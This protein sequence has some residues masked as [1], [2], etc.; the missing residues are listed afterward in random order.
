M[1]TLLCVAVL[2]ILSSCS[3]SPKVYPQNALE[4]IVILGI[5]DF[6]GSL[7]QRTEKTIESD[8]KKA[9]IYQDGGAA[10]FAS[11]VKIL[12]KEQ[13]EKLLVVDAGDEWQGSLDSNL[14]RGST[15]V[16][17][18]NRIGVNVA[19]IGNHEFD[20]GSEPGHPLYGNDLRG[21]MKKRFTEAKYPYVAANI[22]KKGTKNRE[23]FPNTTPTKIFQIGKVKVGVIGLSTT[24]TPE[25][26]RYDA[27]TDLEFR[28]LKDETLEQSK[29]LRNQGADIIIVTTHA[30]V[31]CDPALGESI[32]ENRVRRSN[33]PQG[34]CRDYDELYRYLDS[35]PQGT[36]DLVVSGHTHTILHHWI[37]GTPVIQAGAFNH[38][39]NIATLTY[40]HESKKVVPELTEIEGP[41]PV[42]DK[43]FKN[44]GHCNG[45][46][47][48]PNEG[49]GSLVTAQFHGKPIIPDSEIEQFLKPLFEKTKAVKSKIIGHAARTITHTRWEESE[50]G[51]FYTDIIRE[52][53]HADIGIM[54]SGGIRDSIDEGSISFDK[55]FRALPFDNTIARIEMTG[56]ELGLF[57]RLANNGSHGVFQVSGLT[58][59]MIDLTKEAPADDINGDGKIEHWEVNR[60][61]EIRDEKGNLIDENKTYV[62]ATVDYLAKGGD[63]L[64]WIM[65]QIPKNRMK[66]DAAGAPR[67]A[68]ID[69]L[70][71]HSPVNTKAKPLKNPKKP[72]IILV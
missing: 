23:E 8:G 2:S 71:K 5:N 12:K 70:K 34:E 42:C 7:E 10:V 56:K 47:P 43:V 17:F 16:Q 45:K 54:N 44:L 59:K 55:I 26:T 63:N 6:H 41:V 49:R 60:I 40:D 51:N 61:L 35:I 36:V 19:A 9:T 25:T 38:Y 64:G 58:I 11:F 37:N 66:I 15:V 53:T 22:Y 3:S 18:F 33:A 67:D 14:E 20:F 46:L 50:F 24:F 4:K 72:R 31:T 27:V 1:R 57:F 39:F 62:V 48:A 65:N 28:N 21:A 29:N 52:K 13:G 69:Y 32:Y 30:G 68:I